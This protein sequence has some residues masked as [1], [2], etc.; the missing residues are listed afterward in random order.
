MKKLPFV[1]IDAFASPHSTGNPAGFIQLSSMDE[2]TVEEMQQIGRE[3]QGCVTEVGFACRL[4]PDTVRLRFFSAVREVEFCGHATIGILYT[5]LQRDP[6][7]AAGA[8]VRLYTNK[9]LS[10]V[11]NR[12]AAEDAVYIWAPPPRK[13]PPVPATAEVAQALGLEETALHREWPL[14]VREAGLVTLLVAVRELKPL[15][16][17]QPGQEALRRF[18]VRCGVDIITCFTAETVRPDRQ[19]RTRVF[20]PT[21]GYLEDPATGSGNAAL[22]YYLHELGRWSGDTLAIE[23]NGERDAANTVRLQLRHDDDGAARVLFGGGAVTRIQGEY[24]L[25]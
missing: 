1:K 11:E 10:W 25:G 2:L 3:L 19:Y 20:A 13:G 21:F 24:L 17:L 6:V 4:A 15:L 9:G 8:R 5:L 14:A 22:G 18:C 7:L 23:Q 16:A 12:I